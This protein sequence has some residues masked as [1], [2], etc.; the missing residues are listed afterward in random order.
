MKVYITLDENDHNPSS[1]MF[2]TALVDS[3]FRLA[4]HRRSQDGE[5]LDGIKVKNS[6]WEPYTL[7]A[8][9]SSILADGDDVRVNVSQ[10]KDFAFIHAGES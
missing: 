6:I 8:N 4:R 3:A 10:H 9:G 2:H 1:A 5:E 7:E